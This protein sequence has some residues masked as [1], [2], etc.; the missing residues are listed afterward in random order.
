M[1]TATA[2]AYS[3]SMAGNTRACMQHHTAISMH[4]STR[5]AW[6]EDQGT[7]YGGHLPSVAE[8]VNGPPRY[9]RA[10]AGDLEALLQAYDRERLALPSPVVLWEW[11]WTKSAETWN[12]RLAMVALFVIVFLEITTGQSIMRSILNLN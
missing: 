5:M 11:G 3:L 1:N 2:T 8:N 6:T 9:C 4:G 12:G 7:V 10:T